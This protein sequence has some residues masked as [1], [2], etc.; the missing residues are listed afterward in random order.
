MHIYALIGMFCADVIPVDYD[1]VSVISLM[2]LT[3]VYRKGNK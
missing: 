1:A 3:L 2:V